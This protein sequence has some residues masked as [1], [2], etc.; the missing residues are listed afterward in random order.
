MTLFL[1]HKVLFFLLTFSEKVKYLSFLYI[2]Q[3]NLFVKKLE[4]FASSGKGLLREHF[5]W[6]G[7]CKRTRFTASSAKLCPLWS[8]LFVRIW[9]LKTRVQLMGYNWPVCTSCSIWLRLPLLCYSL[10]SLTLERCQCFSVHV[11]MPD[12]GNNRIVTKLLILIC[13]GLA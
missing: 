9:N 2:Y 5:G 8:V 11:T 4:C 7:T 10:F 13:I 12:L 6:N 1:V 3:L